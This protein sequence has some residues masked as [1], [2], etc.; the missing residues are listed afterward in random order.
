[1][2]LST[3][4]EYILTSTILLTYNFSEFSTAYLVLP[5]IF[6]LNMSSISQEDKFTEVTRTHKKR[7]ANNL[8]T[9]PGQLKQ[10]SFEPSPGTPVRPRPSHNNTIPLMISGVDDKFKNWK[11]LKSVP[12]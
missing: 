4:R 12:Y 10:G 11:Q 2:H 9:V 8:P 3:T 6:Q 7:K 1:M 5:Y